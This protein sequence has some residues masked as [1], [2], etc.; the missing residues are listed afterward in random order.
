MQTLFEDTAA[1]A[2]PPHHPDNQHPFDPQ[3]SH[4]DQPTVALFK[5]VNDNNLSPNESRYEDRNINIT[6]SSSSQSRSRNYQNYQKCL[7]C[8]SIQQC[9]DIHQ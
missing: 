4:V 1:A 3:E 5:D 6:H 9:P 8:Q 2:K 7:R